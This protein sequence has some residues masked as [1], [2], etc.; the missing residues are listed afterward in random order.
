MENMLNNS[1]SEMERDVWDGLWSR[2]IVTL[3]F[4]KLVPKFEQ[5][6][7]IPYRF[8]IN[9]LLKGI[10]LDQAHILELGCGSGM[11]S[12]NLF[13][14]HSCQKA[15][16]IDFSRQALNIA[17]NN[18][19]HLNVDLIHSDIF[20]LN[21]KKK[22][23]FVFS[24]GLI[25]HFIGAR[26]SEAI[27]IHRQFTKDSGLIMIIVPRKNFFS[28][29]LKFFNQ[30]QGYKEDFFSDREIEGLFKRNELEIVKKNYMMLGMVFC[31][32]LRCRR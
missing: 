25:E 11:N 27:K 18:T 26:R 6:T 1:Q 9:K 30:I 32:L 16:L 7:H 14:E 31:Y 23:D 19:R 17:K 24:I 28:K 21:L 2:S 5:L 10:S 20:N 12:V 15:T 4:R 8:N 13:K 22:F 3:W 29:A